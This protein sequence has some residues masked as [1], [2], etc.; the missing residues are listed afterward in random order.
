VASAFSIQPI[1]LT[2]LFFQGTGFHR[3]D[4]AF[5][6]TFVSKVTAES[7]RATPAWN[8]DQEN[9]PVSARTALRLAKELRD[10]VVDTPINAGWDAGS[11]GLLHDG[12]H[13]VWL[14]YFKAARVGDKGKH[15]F[16]AIVLMDGTVVKP[17]VTTDSL[18]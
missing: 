10:T 13:C 5:G 18:D 4:Q 15:R 3:T 8:D 9:P 7:I 1:V 2:L 12:R 6:K 11:F 16:T 14:V 17:T